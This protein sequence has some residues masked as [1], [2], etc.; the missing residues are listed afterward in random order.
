MR[1]HRLVGRVAARRRR[2]QQRR[3]EPAAVLVRALEVEVD[4]LAGRQ[5]LALGDRGPRH[6]RLEPDVDDVV[7]L[8]ERAPAARAGSG[9]RRA[10]ARAAGRANQA[11]APSRA[12]ISATCSIT[13]ASSRSFP[14]FVQ[15]NAGIGTPQ[16]RW[17]DS[18]SRGA[19]RSCRGCGSR[20][21]RDPLRAARSRPARGGAATSRRRRREAREPLL[22]GAEDDRVLAAPAVR[23]LVAHR[24]ARLVEQAGRAP[25]GRRR[26]SGSRR[27]RLARPG[28][29]ARRR[30]ERAVLVDRR[31]DRQPCS[32]P[33]T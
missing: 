3:V 7:L 20:P 27:R 14:H 10:A 24:L 19:P 6:A 12:K 18:T 5:Q 15:R 32:R 2:R 25:R 26:S 31:E 29:R 22:G 8:L 17:R 11:S 23:V 13:S 30:G 28:R 16:T 1:Q 21:R 33:T 4:L 9:R